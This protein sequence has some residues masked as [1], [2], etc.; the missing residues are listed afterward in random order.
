MRAMYAFL[1]T[2]VWPFFNLFHPCRPIGRDH[3]PEGGAVICGNHTT[4]SD[5]LFVAYAVGMGCQLRVMAKAELLRVP[6]VG[7]ILSKAGI[8][9]VDRGKADVGAIKTAMK[10]LKSGEKVLLFPEGTRIRGGVDKDGHQ[11]EAKTGAVMLAMRTGVPIVPVY[12][13]E[14]KR[15]FRR[16]TIVIG[17]PYLPASAEKR[18][19]AEEYQQAADDLMVRIHALRPLET[20]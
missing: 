6:V 15:W 3:I 18:P 9:G 5:P 17:E 13:P 14:K 2:L 12:I 4:V 16:T 20:A 8:F 10:F 7:W 1:I 11:S 19:T